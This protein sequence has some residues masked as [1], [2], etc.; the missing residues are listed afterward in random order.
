MS[1]LHV[2]VGIDV[3]KAQRDSAGRPTG[4][5]WAV[6]HDAPGMA[7]LVVRL[8]AVQPRRIGLEAP[9]GS[10]R[11][12][13]AARAAAFPGVVVN[14]RQG[15]DCAQATGQ[16][17]TTDALDARAIAHFA[18]AVRPTPRPLPDAQT[19]ELRA[20]VARRRQLIAMRTAEYNRLGR[21]SGR[22]W[23]DIQAHILWLDQRLVALDDDLDTMLHAS[24]VWRERDELYRS[25]PGIGPV[26]ARTLV[27]DLPELGTLSRQRIAALVGV[28]PF[29][30]D[31]GTLRGRR[32]IWG[33][34]A[35]VRATLYMSALVAVRH[36]PILKAFY[37]RLCAA[38]K[39]KKV[40]LTACMHKLLTI[41]NAMVKHQTP[42]QSREVSIA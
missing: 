32:T 5:R 24:P 9:G 17:A 21:A 1:V 39:A 20:L 16:L 4:A 8:Q 25:V 19:E 38:G 6:G 26:C 29:N 3:A 12:V 27:L 31:S 34:R 41:L 35:A 37:E 23:A 28:A 18:E 22:L 10:Q 40:A 30:R 2:C 7:A 14:P 15:R 33:G 13:V 42:W 11:A 36:N